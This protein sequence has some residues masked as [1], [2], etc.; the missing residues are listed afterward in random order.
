MPIP[1]TIATQ[2]LLLRPFK[3]RDARVLPDLLGD[4]DVARWLARAPH[5]YTLEDG[6]DWIKVS[7]SIR[8]RRL[9]I[10]LAVVEQESGDLVGGVGLDFDS[11]EVG[12]W[13]GKAYWGQG[14]ATEAVEALTDMG[15]GQAALPKLWAGVMPGNDASCRVLEKIGYRNHGTRPYRFR[16]FERAA[17]YYR[18]QRWEW[19]GGQ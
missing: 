2:H 16:D 8:R 3:R 14:Y 12:Y 10:S 1:R 15:L 9:G 17:L 19:L 4:W 5:P 7:R 18:I 6:R 11:C 13:F